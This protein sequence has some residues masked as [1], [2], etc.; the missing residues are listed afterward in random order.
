MTRLASPHAP[1][2]LDQVLSA[3]SPKDGGDYV[4]GTFG[5]GGYTSAILNAANTRVFAIDRDPRA[6]KRAEE[7]C[8]Q[9]YGDNL[10]FLPGTFGSMKNLLAE[11]SIDAVDGIALDVG[12]SSMQL[13]DPERGF[14][15]RFDGPLDMRMGGAGETAADVVNT[16]SEED[17]ATIIYTLGEERASRR[18][19]RAIVIARTDAPI[20]RT[21]QFADI[22][23]SAV[24]KSKASKSKS[25]AKTIDPATRTFQAFRIYVND[26]LGELERG[27]SAAE[28]LL[29]PGGRLCVVSF[30]SLEDRLVKDFLKSRSG[31]AP[32][33]SRHA[34]DGGESGLAPSF[35]LLNRGAIK[36]DEAE[37]AINPRARSAR[38]RWAVR[39]EAQAWPPNNEKN[40]PR[41]RV[42]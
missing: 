35:K 12:V 24:P 39:T 37:I 4:D 31:E 27:L 42:T 8:A 36:S 7:L 23:R 19:A 6:Q 22:V 21:G 9:G 1:V 3:L 11:R 33:A 40:D 18:V 29:K 38:L 13:D 34:P 20:T 14:S 5:F 28:V 26:E 17:L 10:V 41:G 16:A 25:G 2:L 30:H 32:R 15:F